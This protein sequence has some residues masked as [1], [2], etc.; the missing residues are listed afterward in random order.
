MTGWNTA[1][2]KTIEL[3]E[4]LHDV[5]A[6][7][8]PN[9]LIGAKDIDAALAPLRFMDSHRQGPM[10]A[11]EVYGPREVF[12]EAILRIMWMIS[13]ITEDHVTVSICFCGGR[14]SLTAP[15]QAYN[16]YFSV[17]SMVSQL[18]H[19]RNQAAY[20]KYGRL[21]HKHDGERLAKRMA[22]PVDRVIAAI[23]R[24]QNHELYPAVRHWCAQFVSQQLFS[25]VV[26][27]SYVLS[28]LLS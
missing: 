18:I 21:E 10:P 22:R 28:L 2:P 13:F 24:N 7:G 9:P 4:R 17:I 25:H 12:N 6:G 23:V 8:N 11:L 5:C 27:A 26:A 14:S 3:L 16:V 20:K 19:A 15:S 1:V